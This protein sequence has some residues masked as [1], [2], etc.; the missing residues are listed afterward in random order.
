MGTGRNFAREEKHAA[1]EAQRLQV[2]QE[3]IILSFSYAILF[4][5]SFAAL[6]LPG[7]SSKIAG[8]VAVI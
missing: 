2:L 6:F 5:F 3:F 1:T 4:Y 8:A 7:A